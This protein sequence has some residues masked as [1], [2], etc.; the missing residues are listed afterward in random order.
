MADEQSPLLAH[1]VEADVPQRRS[2]S[3]IIGVLL[4][5]KSLFYSSNSKF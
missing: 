3:A 1:D 2:V 4:I 5:G